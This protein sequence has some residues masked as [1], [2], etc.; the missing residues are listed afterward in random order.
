MIF[1]AYTYIHGLNRIVAIAI[2]HTFVFSG[3]FGAKGRIRAL[4]QGH[5]LGH[6]AAVRDED[7][8]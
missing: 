1:R 6:R 2:C 3:A 8:A 4:L 7:R 5:L